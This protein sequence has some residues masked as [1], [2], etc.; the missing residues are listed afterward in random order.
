MKLKN[1]IQRIE[2]SPTHSP[3]TSPD[4]EL[5]PKRIRTLMKSVVNCGCTN[6]CRASYDDSQILQSNC[7]NVTENRL[8]SFSNC[9]SELCENRLPSNQNDFL[10]NRKTASK[11]NGLFSKCLIKNGQII[12]EY[13]GE[14]LTKGQFDSRTKQSVNKK[15]E[16]SAFK[17][18]CPIWSFLEIFRIIFGQKIK[19]LNCTVCDDVRGREIR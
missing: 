10:L 11:G 2:I 17:L 19:I 9:D 4:Y 15:L 18:L 5:K 16:Y 7:P 6:K 1:E 3:P 12:G 8:C 13:S 14:I